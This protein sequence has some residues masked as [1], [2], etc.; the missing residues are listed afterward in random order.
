[1]SVAPRSFCHEQAWPEEGSSVGRHDDHHRSSPG[2]VRWR[3]RVLRHGQ[4]ERLALD[5]FGKKKTDTAFKKYRRTANSIS[6]IAPDPVDKDWKALTAAMVE[7][8][9]AQKAAGLK[10]QDVTVDSVAGLST[11]Q[12][13]G[14]SSAYEKFTD[15]VPPST[16]RR[17]KTTSRANV[18]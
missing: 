4:G 9:D 8:K 1:M 17:S 6:K 11:A 12:S 3:Q 10:P 16:A 18:A 15:A 5:S 14:L 7:V 13:A 2:R